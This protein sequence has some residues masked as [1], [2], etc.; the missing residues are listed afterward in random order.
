MLLRR[1]NPL[2]A[3]GV[4]LRVRGYGFAVFLEAR[5]L[6][7]SVYVVLVMDEYALN[8]EHRGP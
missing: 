6:V 7:V 8:W 5:L 2:L 4:F 3:S 1:R